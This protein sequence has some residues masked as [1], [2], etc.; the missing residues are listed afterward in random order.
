VEAQNHLF[1]HPYFK[2]YVLQHMVIDRE[3]DGKL[4]GFMFVEQSHLERY[5]RYKAIKEEI[6]IMHEKLLRIHQ[7]MA[8]F[9]FEGQPKQDDQ[10]PLL[11]ETPD[12]KED[13]DK[14][15]DEFLTFVEDQ[16]LELLETPGEPVVPLNKLMEACKEDYSEREK[17]WGV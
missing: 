12:K 2:V 16:A 5:W 14:F 17:A 1:S 11:K 9:V 4:R 6:D 13:Q 15:D 7:F 10:Q 3:T 8:K